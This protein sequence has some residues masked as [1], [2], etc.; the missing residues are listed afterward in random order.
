[1]KRPKRMARNN[2]GRRDVVAAVGA[3]ALPAEIRAGCK[4]QKL[5]L[6][7]WNWQLRQPILPESTC[8]FR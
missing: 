1:M 3:A 5:T 7:P 2:P 8:T 4:G 6:W